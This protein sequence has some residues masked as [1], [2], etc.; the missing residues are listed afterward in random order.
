LIADLYSALSKSTFY[1]RRTGNPGE[2]T[3]WIDVGE[4]LANH[5]ETGGERVAAAAEALREAIDDIRLASRAD[6]RDPLVMGLSV[7]FPAN[8]VGRNTGANDRGNDIEETDA[9][10]LEGGY[11][12]ILG[13]FDVDDASSAIGSLRATDVEPP[14]L[15][16]TVV[17]VGQEDVTLDFAAADDVM[18]VNG[19]GILL[20]ETDD[21]EQLAVV[22]GRVDSIGVATYS[23][24]A[25]L[26]RLAV[27]VGP[28]DVTPSSDS[29][30][31]LSRKDDK[32]SVPVALTKG[33]RE[34]RGIL[35]LAEGGVIEALGAVRE[36]GTW[37]VLPWEDA[38]ALPGL[39]IA[40]L[41][42]TV[43]PMTGDYETRE[44]DRTPVSEAG[45]SFVELDD[46]NRLS[47][48]LSVTDLAGNV[49]LSGST[50]E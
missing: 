16:F 8:R 34:E 29:V 14:T 35:I 15:D 10:L 38:V 49:T 48:L 50:L 47:L 9:R 40:P 17:D 7:Y 3:S 33:E 44:G 21:Q 39:E 26:P 22:A 32:Y 23:G 30:G 11:G 36:N 25:T 20:F 18:L 12:D 24:Q 19:D 5:T 37:A 41:S 4:F 6:G 43:D 1:N 2:Q 27:L 13:L 46:T 42:F 31:F 28:D 45:V